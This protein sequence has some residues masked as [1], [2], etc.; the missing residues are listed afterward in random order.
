MPSR[1]APPT[2]WKGFLRLSL[3]TIAIELY[4]AVETGAGIG[5]NMIHKPSGKRVNYTK[6]VGG[7]PV[8]NSD[9]VKGYPIERDT[10]VTFTSEE[11]DAVRLE[12]KKTLDL[13]EFVD[14]SQIEPALFRAA[15]LHRAGR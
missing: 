4:N 8:E 12:T 6:T 15:L 7:E 11:L 13:S 2:L 14:A 9:I 10:Y 3:V 5:F 1:K